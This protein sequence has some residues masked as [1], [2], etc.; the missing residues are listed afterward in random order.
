MLPRGKV[1]VRRIFQSREGDS[2]M[3]R[4][5]QSHEICNIIKDEDV[6][7]ITGITLG[8]FDEEAII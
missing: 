7:M 4:I 8:G 3:K 6:F 1:P 5:I 2:D